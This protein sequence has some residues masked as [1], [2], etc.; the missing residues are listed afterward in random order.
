MRLV[1][2]INYPLKLVQLVPTI[3]YE[4]HEFTRYYSIFINFF[5]IY[6]KVNLDKKSFQIR[7]TL[8]HIEQPIQ[9][10]P[11]RYNR[12]HILFAID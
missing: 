5:P 6:K 9:G 3:L 12:I 10:P 4:L 8:R 1:T 2:L 11:R 7:H